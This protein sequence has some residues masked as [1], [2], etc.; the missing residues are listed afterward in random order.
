MVDRF[1]AG[2]IALW[3]GVIALPVMSVYLIDETLWADDRLYVAWFFIKNVPLFLFYLANLVIMMRATAKEAAALSF[4]LF[5]AIVPLGFMIG[6]A[7]LPLLEDM[8]GW[9]AMFG[10][11]AV[12]IFV[13]G[14]LTLLLKP[15]TCPQQAEAGTVEFEGKFA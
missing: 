12:M 5:A 6:A 3:S 13:A 14:L 11:S 1:G 2:R 9:Q 10:A 4:A 7:L 8:G 15:D